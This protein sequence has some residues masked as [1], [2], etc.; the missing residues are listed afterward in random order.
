VFFEKGKVTIFGMYSKWFKKA[1]QAI[2][3]FPE[4]ADW[5]PLKTQKL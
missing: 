5:I 1:E 4:I 3:G 2:I